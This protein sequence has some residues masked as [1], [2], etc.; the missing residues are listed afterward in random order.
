MEPCNSGNTSL[1]QCFIKEQASETIIDANIQNVS[2][3][4]AIRQTYDIFIRGRITFENSKLIDSITSATPQKKFDKLNESLNSGISCNRLS[5]DSISKGGWTLIH[6][7]AY[8]GNVDLIQFFLKNCDKRLINLKIDKNIPPLL[9][10]VCCKNKKN[11]YKVAKLLLNFG[12]NPNIISSVDGN[13]PH[14]I[15]RMNSVKVSTLIGNISFPTTPIL[16]AINSKRL[17][18]FQLLTSMNGIILSPFN[19][20]INHL[21]DK[22][23]KKMKVIFDSYKELT[24]IGN[25]FSMN[26]DLIK[27]IGVNLLR[28][29]DASAPIQHILDSQEKKLMDKI[30][31]LD[32]KSASQQRSKPGQ[33]P[34]RLLHFNACGIL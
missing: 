34:Q 22:F 4:E 6:K 27:V 16:E 7:A 33:Q 17:K 15:H 20:E 18:M 30:I 8:E 28:L 32:N 31:S 13:L 1:F 2:A 25:N 12:A 9:C 26:Y 10:A 23:L 3:T 14:E 19:K 21:E 24:H 5:F 29:S 11:G